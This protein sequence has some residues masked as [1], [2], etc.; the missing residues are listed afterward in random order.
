MRIAINTRFLLSHKMEG[1]GWYT[2]E[3]VSRMVNAHPEHDFFFF[4]DRK[5]DSK[6]V[7]AKNVTPIVLN[8]PARHPILFKIWFNKSVT[9]ALKKY[10]I[11]AFISPDGYVSLKTNVPQLAVIHDLNFEHHP[12]DVPK[13][14]RNYLKRFFPLFAKKAQRILTVSEYSKLDI[15]ETYGIS[16]SKIDVAYNG[17]APFFNP[18]DDN[19]KLKTRDR[20]TGGKEYF[21]FVGSL[22]PRKNLKRLLAA[23]DQFK[24]QDE[25]DRYLVIVGESLWGN[26]FGK[27]LMDQVKFKDFV[28]FT[29]HVGSDELHRTVGSAMAMTFV[30]YFEGF[31]IPVA[32]AMK[33]G[34]PVILSDKTS[35]PEVG[36]E[37]AHY[38]DPFDVNSIAN[39]MILLSTNEDYRKEMSDKSL[40]QAEK[41][42]WDDTAEGM[43]RSFEKMITDLK[44]Q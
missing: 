40:I 44:I 24:E 28:V 14:A 26:S 18:I 10:K 43:W 23:F 37:A 25:N 20:L 21:V 36:G 3:T 41:F 27:Q 34:V 2:F 35:L 22:H 42:S 31:G 17:V 38:V 12:E 8:P 33:C 5:F 6:F 4:F 9:R 11:D 16:E 29:G 30:S 39:A 32:E 7:F 15:V 1:F 19:L 13:S